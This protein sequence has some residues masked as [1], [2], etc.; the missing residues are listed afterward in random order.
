MLLVCQQSNDYEA[1]EDL[2][3]LLELALTVLDPDEDVDT[4]VV[5]PHNGNNLP[6]FRVVV[7]LDLEEA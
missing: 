1:L 3:P 5:L 7:D 4:S 6:A 2:V